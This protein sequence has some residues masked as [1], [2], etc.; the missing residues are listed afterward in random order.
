MK[1]PFMLQELP[2]WKIQELQEE[3]KIRWRVVDARIPE[4][5][6]EQECYLSRIHPYIAGGYLLKIKEQDRRLRL[7]GN[8]NQTYPDFHT[9][10]I[11]IIGQED[12]EA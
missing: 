3:E 2:M 4:E 10:I 1:E 11:E 7:G 9:L 8:G 6:Q 5:F 12:E